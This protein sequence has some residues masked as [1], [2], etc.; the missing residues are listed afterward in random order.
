MAG[1][2]PKKGLTMNRIQPL[3][4]AQVTGKTKQLFDVAKGKMGMIP[5]TLRVLG[6][7]PAVLEGYLG[8]GAAVS[9]TSL[10][11]KIR[12]QIFL[13]I[14]E[15]NGCGYCLSAHT[16]TGRH[17]GLS[18]DDITHARQGTGTDEKADAAVKFARKLSQQRGK[19][20]ELDLEAARS[21]SLS[22]AELVEVVA[23]VT[24]ITFTNYANNAFDPVIDFPEVK[25][26]VF[27]AET[28]VAATA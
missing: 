27:P 15:L 25:P 17:A 3:D 14:S 6:H 1:N 7:S 23:A 13:T 18:K 11:P 24:L 9:A 20:T 4:P 2:H 12:E 19:V 8:L 16:L 10:P 28:P 22:D 5:N 21:A 26:G